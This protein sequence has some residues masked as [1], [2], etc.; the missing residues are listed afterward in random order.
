[1][2]PRIQEWIDREAENTKVLLRGVKRK[3]LI[4]TPLYMLIAFAAMVALGFAVGGLAAVLNTHLYVGLGVAAFVGLCSFV[5]AGVISPKTVKKAY[6]KAAK[7]S[8]HTPE[9]E[10]VFCNQMSTGDYG[11]VVFSEKTLPFP[12][13]V[14]IGPQY[15]VYRNTVNGSFIKVADIES[16]RVAQRRIHV[17]EG[18]AV[19]DTVSG[20]CIIVNYR[21]DLNLKLLD[22]V[23]GLDFDNGE[24]LK[25]ALRLIEQYCPQI[26]VE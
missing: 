13:K 14:I 18:R 17:Q 10:S 4:K 2:T 26:T 24:S 6:E 22:S 8:F 9:D 25:T 19:S 20:V 12:S 21:K 7:S 11:E 1:M 3:R 15:W 5:T 16:A 23:D